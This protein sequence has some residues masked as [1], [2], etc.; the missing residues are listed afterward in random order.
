[1]AHPPTC[2][3]CDKRV[4]PVWRTCP[5]CE[6]VL[7]G[8][9]TGSRGGVLH[10]ALER[11]SDLPNKPWTAIPALVGFFFLTCL[12]DVPVVW[13]AILMDW[14]HTSVILLT[15]VGPALVMCVAVICAHQRPYIAQ[16]LGGVAYAVLAFVGLLLISSCAVGGLAVFL[17]SWVKLR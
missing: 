3:R 12:L 4:E 7:K 10:G 1:M 2:P 11:L 13:A 17:M 15:L 8:P 14:S 6:A 9:E 16:R 5:N